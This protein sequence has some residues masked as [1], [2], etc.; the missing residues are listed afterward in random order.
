MS[1]KRYTK[2][3]LQ[4][5]GMDDQSSLASFQMDRIVKNF[6]KLSILI[7]MV[8]FI[9]IIL[10]AD[11]ACAADS[12]VKIGV[13][14][15]R[16]VERCLAKWS[17]TA[18]YLAEALPG[19]TFEIVPI[20]FDHITQMVEKGLVNFI[21]A[22]SSIYVELEVKYG[23]NRIAT[24][25]NK[26]LN[27]I[28]TSFGGVIFCLKSRQNIQNMLDLKGKSFMAVEKTSFG[29]WRM[30]WRELKEAGLDPLSDFSSLQFGGTHDAVVYAVRNGKVNAGTVRTDTLERMQLEGKINLD[31]F[32]IIHK[33]GGDIH[34]PF[35]H[36]TRAYPEWPFA[37][38]K[39]TPDELAEKVAIALLEMSPNSPAAKTAN[40]AGWTIPSNYQPVHECLKELKLT[41][42]EDLGKI[43]LADVIRKYWHWILAISALFIV[44]AGATFVILK[45][46]RNIKAAHIKLQSEVEKQKQAEKAL[47]E[48]KE[49]LRIM[50]ATAK[51][52][53]IM[54]DNETNISYW[55]NAAQEMFGYVE[56]DIIGKELHKFLI[57]DK[58][59]ESYI[60]GF[61]KFKE[62]GQGAAVDKTLELSAMRK[63]GIEFPVELSMSA[64]KI[65]DK[66]HAVGIIR[67][68]T[69]RK[70]MEEE[71]RRLS[72]SDGLTG[73]ANRRYF[74]E[75]FDREW[76]RALRDAKPISLIMCDI[77][78]F[79][80]YNDT[81]GHQ[82]GDDALRKVGNEINKKMKRPGDLAARYGGEEFVV[83]LPDTDS[84]G[85]AALA[86]DIREGVEAMGIQHKNSKAGEVLTISLGVANRIPDRTSYPANLIAMA[87]KA[88]YKAKEEGR[89]RVCE[90]IEG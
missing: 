14:A 37:K 63:D 52:A 6:I 80:A 76:K 90:T 85:A 72:N 12:T 48:S 9:A 81:Y 7:I 23:V 65:K 46:N 55:N 77:D 4:N 2:T 57:P 17:P 5:N 49:R 45:L 67:D 1:R 44:M 54:I 21:L 78:Y 75:R 36:S 86:E 33:H 25:K 89:N 50:A 68:I 73:I 59:Y 84:K 47:Q 31:D 39:D 3:I 24:L 16:G 27:G 42:Y 15:K 10:M 87:D 11:F 26:R 82:R 66:W 34:F 32:H 62:T 20:D 60:K 8:T 83:L 71:L 88:L 79:K 28:Y 35:L 53:I 41:P 29:G 38:L 51:D 30:A 40:C 64:I 61:S 74:D 43:T 22:N 58:Y 19:K 70:E 13:L 56:Q 69:Q 18:D